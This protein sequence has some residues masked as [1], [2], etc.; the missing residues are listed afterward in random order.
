MPFIR[1]AQPNELAVAVAID[2]DASA[3]YAEAGIDLSFADD[4]PF[5]V[6]E[7]ARWQ[8]CLDAGA[9]HF[10]LD[11]DQPVGFAAVERLDGQP[12][13]EQLSVRPAFGRRGIGAALLQ[14]AIVHA[15]A[16]LTLTTYRHLPWNAPWY[17]RMGFRVLA[18][19]EQSNALRARMK[20]E[21]RAL[22]MPMM[23]VAMLR[24]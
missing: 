24:R 7:R 4:H 2:R 19:H 17:A 15:V 1:V 16:P 14:T 12:H 5:A 13:L 3:L 6:A 21:R 11:G 8:R 18:N 20:E 22:P 23:R 9:V 10:A